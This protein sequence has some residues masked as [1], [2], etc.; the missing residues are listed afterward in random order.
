MQSCC[1][2]RHEA[3]QECCAQLR[4]SPRTLPVLP[5]L[6]SGKQQDEEEDSAWFRQTAEAAASATLQSDAHRGQRAMLLSHLVSLPVFI[7]GAPTCHQ[8]RQA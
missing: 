3:A 8:F 5:G 2:G 7:L 1:E 4:D 6:S